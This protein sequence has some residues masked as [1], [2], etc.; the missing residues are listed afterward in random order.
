MDKPCNFHN[1]LLIWCGLIFTGAVE[2]P[3][4]KNQYAD[5]AAGIGLGRATGRR[6]LCLPG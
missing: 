3:I 6:D 1:F 2:Q 4:W 5:F